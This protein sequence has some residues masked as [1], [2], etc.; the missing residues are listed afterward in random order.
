M[1]VGAECNATAV[2]V[3]GTGNVVYD[4]Q[5]LCEC[6]IFVGIAFNFV[7]VVPSGSA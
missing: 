6:F 5:R 2:M 4:N 7:F 1:G 3:S